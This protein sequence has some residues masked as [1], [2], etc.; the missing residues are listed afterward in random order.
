MHWPIHLVLAAVFSEEL[1]KIFV[2]M[3]RIKSKKWINN[4]VS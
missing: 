2:V 1:L 3:K 4:L